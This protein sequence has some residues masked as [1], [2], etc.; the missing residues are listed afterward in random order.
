ML[1]FILSNK[2]LNLTI[3]AYACISVSIP[4]KL[5][6]KSIISKSIKKSGTLYESSTSTVDKKLNQESRLH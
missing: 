3:L 6:A 5:H 1:L 2:N 4:E